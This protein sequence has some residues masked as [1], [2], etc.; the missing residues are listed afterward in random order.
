MDAHR[1]P[2]AG[3]SR[4]LYVAMALSALVSIA[5]YVMLG[6]LLIDL[7]R[8]SD[9]DDMTSLLWLL[10]TLLSVPL[11]IG[12]ILYTIFRARVTAAVGG[13]ATA[14]AGFAWNFSFG[15]REIALLLLAPTALI[16]LIALWLVTRKPAA[17]QS[18]LFSPPE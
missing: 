15:E 5:V 18:Y 7:V 13:L 11:T 9:I 10:A 3:V 12:A 14:F 6:K 8:S 16:V 17:E 1:S 2:I 4:L